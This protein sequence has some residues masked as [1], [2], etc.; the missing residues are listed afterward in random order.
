MKGKTDGSWKRRQDLEN[1]TLALP[2]SNP[3]RKILEVKT[4]FSSDGSCNSVSFGSLE[5]ERPETHWSSV[6][7]SAECLE[8]G[9]RRNITLILTKRTCRVPSRL[10]INCLFGEQGWVIYAEEESKVFFKVHLFFMLH[11]FHIYTLN[12]P[13][14][15]I[16]TW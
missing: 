2:P 7:N 14:K 3:F 8:G 16:P 6:F 5:T 15:Y 11:D 1:G 9:G 10:G 12:P 13:G 4:I